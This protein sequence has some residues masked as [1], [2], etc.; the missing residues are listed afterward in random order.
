[1]YKHIFWDSMRKP[2]LSFHL[3]MLLSIVF[4]KLSEF[5][6]NVNSYI[7]FIL[8]ATYKVV[9]IQIQMNNFRYGWTE[10]HMHENFLQYRHGSYFTIRNVHNSIWYSINFEHSIN[11]HQYIL[12]RKWKI[13]LYSKLKLYIKFKLLANKIPKFKSWSSINVLDVKKL[14]TTT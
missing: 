11:F 7:L 1:M 13:N 10:V 5:F 12:S 6:F 2:N 8:C 9:T 14:P 3:H 4:C